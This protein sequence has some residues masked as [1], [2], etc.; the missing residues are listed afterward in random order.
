M[1]RL[2][3]AL[4]TILEQEIKEYKQIFAL[5][6]EKKQVL[7]KND[8]AGLDRI[9][10]KEWASIEKIKELETRR[11]GHMG[12]IAALCHMPEE[13]LR[14]EHI[15]EVLRDERQ[16]VFICLREELARVLFELSNLNLVN[17]GLIDTHLAYSDF[18][19][20]LLRG[21]INLTLGT[22]SQTGTVNDRHEGSH[23]LLN[24]TV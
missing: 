3:T 5:A 11:E 12:Q 14:M 16:D 6:K 1:D 24:Q 19:V 13:T 21:Q 2:I 22:Y 8:L 18:C 15:I 17:K 23:L 10:I 7:I 20:N 9:V 4:Q